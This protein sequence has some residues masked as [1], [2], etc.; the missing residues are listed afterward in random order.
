MNIAALEPEDDLFRFGI[1][2]D[3]LLANRM[4]FS[5]FSLS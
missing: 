4:G 2:D 5:L 1:V 3:K